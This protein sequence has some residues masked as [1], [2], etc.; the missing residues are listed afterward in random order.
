[1]KKIRK[2]QKVQ[3]KLNGILGNPKEP[4]AWTSFLAE[5]NSKGLKG[6]QRILGNHKGPKGTL[7]K[8][9]VPQGTQKN[10]IHRQVKT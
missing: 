3:F 7:K 5:R 6:T 1:M 10:P 2:T 9:K 8:P 4:K